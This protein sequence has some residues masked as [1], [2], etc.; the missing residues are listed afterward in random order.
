[1]RVLVTGSQGKVGRAT[2][3]ALIKQG[4]E[5]RAVDLAPPA[6]E[7]KGENEPDYFQANLT[8]PGDA[9]AVVRGMDAASSAAI[10]T[11]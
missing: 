1:M 10:T 6:F 3:A 11:T 8:E 4:H 2:V 9:F 7:R 5:V